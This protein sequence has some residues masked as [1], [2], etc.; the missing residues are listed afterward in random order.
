MSAYRIL[1]RK[2][3]GARLSDSEIAG[4]VRGAA[5]GS[6]GD[7]QLAA[8]LMAA[9]IRGLDAGE[10]RSLT[11]SMRDS[12]ALWELREALP[13]VVDKH[14]TGGVGDKAS[15]TLAPLLAECGVPI[16]ML[17][18]RGL[19]HTGGT[20][21]KLESI[22][23]IDL[24]LDRSRT[25]HLLEKVGIAIGIA[26]EAIAPADRRLY[27]LRDRTATVSSI[28]LVIA[29][30]LSKKL[31]AGA[32][33]IV[34]DVKTG[35]GAVFPD[36]AD[37]IELARRLVE[38]STELG[39]PASALLTDMSQPLGE[40]VGHGAEVTESLNLL[41]GEGDDRLRELTLALAHEA[42]SRGGHDLSRRRLMEVLASGAARERF[43]RWA[44]AQGA[45]P[46]WCAAPELP[47]AP[48][49][50]PILAPEKGV[51]A[52]VDTRRLGMALGGAARSGPRLDPGVALHYRVRLGASVEAG[53]E[54]AR[55]YL[56]VARPEIVSEVA[57]CFSIGV[58]GVAPPLVVERIS[59]S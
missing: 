44:S 26:T 52:A 29:S 54:L 13:G 42:A 17:T 25:V 43:L 24:S 1:E 16:A 40:W 10:G 51:V 33:G 59:P 48:V 12:G 7:D 23:G 27:Q 4:V 18:G 11:L 19:G 3:S 14:S 41:S 31:A 20:A 15:L 37:G 45:E 22:P 57:D 2:R 47:L 34:F 8:F 49:V 56:S 30:I 9:A 38:T 58:T 55:L 36:R 5:D 39:C 35:N 50:V 6:W 46:G 53:E 21:D 28:P 32:T